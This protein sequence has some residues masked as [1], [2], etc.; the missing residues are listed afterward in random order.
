MIEVTAIWI[1]LCHN[2]Y[3]QTEKG[4]QT[5]NPTVKNSLEKRAM[6]KGYSR[7]EAINLV[8][9]I[10]RDMVKKGYTYV[11]ERYITRL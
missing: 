9:L 8:A 6:L 10:E 4:V 2:V 5:M 11:Y 1:F 7:K 3:I